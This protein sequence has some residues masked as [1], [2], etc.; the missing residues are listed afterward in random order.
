[1]CYTEKMS[2]YYSD[3]HPEI[4]G[5]QIELLRRVPPWKKLEM[6]AQLNA[7]ARQLALQGLRQRFPQ[8]GETELNRR[9]AGLLL[10]EELAS[11]VYGRL[12]DA[13]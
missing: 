9:L 10:G 11:K 3:S 1:M 2:S 8:A 4:E 6:M 5:L 12:K 13:A 7:S